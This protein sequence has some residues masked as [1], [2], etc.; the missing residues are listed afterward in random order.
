MDLSVSEHLTT[1]KRAAIS[2]YKMNAKTA[3]GW[4]I[5]GLF[6]WLTPMLELTERVNTFE[7]DWHYPIKESDKAANITPVFEENWEKAHQ[8]VPRPSVSVSGLRSAIWKTYKKSILLA[9]YTQFFVALTEVG[10]A[11]LIY[12]SIEQVSKIHYTRKLALILPQCYGVISLVM[13]YMAFKFVSNLAENATNHTLV[14]DG[15]KL[16]ACL[17][18]LMYKKILVKNFDRDPSLDL[19]EVINLTQVDGNRFAEMFRMMPL[20][21]SIP[22]KITFGLAGLFL[23]MGWAMVPTLGVFFLMVITYYLLAILHEHNMRNYLSASDSRIKFVS[24]LFSNLKFIKM[25]GSENVFMQKFYNLRLNEIGWIWRIF[26]R[27]SMLNIIQALC[28]GAFV[29]L[30]Y[31]SKLRRSQTLS[32]SEAIT[33]TI[34]FRTF[35]YSTRLISQMGAHIKEWLVSG[36]RITLF[37]LSEEVVNSTGQDVLGTSFHGRLDGHPIQISR[38]WYYWEEMHVRNQKQGLKKII[39]G[40]NSD[41]EDEANAHIAQSPQVLQ[42][43]PLLNR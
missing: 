21:I 41:E 4:S 13:T 14:K 23:L 36:R 25:C 2:V 27:W 18:H 20:L 15:Y 31:I 7:Q 34:I 39:R 1:N 40:D 11:F 9:I 33:A 10:N 26:V 3:D 19:G 32:L 38:G 43:I 28:T 6:A 17:E 16:R 37:F 29:V 42:T 35:I 8:D 22:M 5:F 30:M 24:E 12:L